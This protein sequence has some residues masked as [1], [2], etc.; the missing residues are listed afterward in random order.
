MWWKV[1]RPLAGAAILAALLWR[2]GT[3]P[4][5]DAVTMINGWSLAA[6]V[7]IA[8]VTTLCCAWRWSLVARGL[9]VGVSLPAAVAAYYRSQ[10]LNMALPGGVLGDVHRGVRHGRDVGDL[11]RGLRAVVWER[12]AGQLVQA[13]LTVLV[14]LLLPSPV[15]STVAVVAVALVAGGLGVLVLV[16][17]LPGGGPSWWRRAVRFV[18]TDI[19][20]GLLRRRIWPGALL[21]STVVVAG[22]TATFVI[23]ARTAGTNVSTSRLLPLAVLV[24][25]AAAVPMNLGG[26]GPREGVAAASF[27]MAGLGAAQGVAAAVV[28]GLMALVAAVPGAVVLLVASLRRRQP[29]DSVDS[30]NFQSDYPLSARIGAGTSIV[31]TPRR[32]DNSYANTVRIG[33]R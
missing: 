3:G 20:Q 2:L 24:L 22:H 29:A 28:S 6:A 23:A 19:R 27:G 7:G 32:A 25:L 31:P 1:L 4:F 12:V 15:R 26:W 30:P 8:G 17:V 10:F 9:G 33:D 11:G 5:R 16:R 21:A 18:G 14:L 13:G